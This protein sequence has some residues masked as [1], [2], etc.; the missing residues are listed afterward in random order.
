MWNV[1][2]ECLAL[3]RIQKVPGSNLYTLTEVLNVVV[4]WLASLLRI[5]KVPGSYL[6]TLTEVLNV[7]VLW[8]ISL[9]RIRKVPGSNLTSQNE[10]SEF[11]YSFRQYLQGN[12]GV[13]PKNGSRPLPSQS[14]N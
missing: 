13:V 12:V 1:T 8:L 3:L 7:V 2:V 14:V 6:Y 11:F 5:R 9:L 10:Y 4:I